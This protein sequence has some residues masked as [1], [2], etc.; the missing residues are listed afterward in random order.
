MNDKATKKDT[1]ELRVFLEGSTEY[2]RYMAS[3][4][5]L[6][7]IEKA[8]QKDH[9][10]ENFG[11][12]HPPASQEYAKALSEHCNAMHD[13]VMALM[14][15]PQAN[16]NQAFIGFTRSL[17]NSIQYLIDEQQPDAS[18]SLGPAGGAERHSRQKKRDSSNSSLGL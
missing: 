1:Q 5:Q 8:N 6:E 7:S 4:S 11:V 10:H 17:K 3:I 12:T 16:L 2:R 13:L 18:E 15:Q 14:K 9:S